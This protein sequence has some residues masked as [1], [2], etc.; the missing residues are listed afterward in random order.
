[1]LTTKVSGLE[2]V[3]VVVMGITEVVTGRVG[4][5]TVAVVITKVK[6]VA[7]V[8]QIGRA[9]IKITPITKLRLGGLAKDP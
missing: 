2:T 1:M 3:T 9:V 8:C 4:V 6:T 7:E 5:V